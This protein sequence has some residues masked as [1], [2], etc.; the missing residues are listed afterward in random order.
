MPKQAIVT[1]VMLEGTDG[2]KMSTSQGNIISIVDEPF[3]MFGKIMSLRDELIIKYFTMCTD[4]TLDE[5]KEIEKLLKKE[6]PRDIKMRLA[7]EIVTLYHNEKAATL[8]RNSFIETFQKGGVPDDIATYTVKEGEE[9]GTVLVKEGV[10]PSKSE[11]RRLIE[12]NAV[13]REDD[14]V[15]TDPKVLVTDAIFKIGKKRFAKIVIEK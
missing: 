2:N 14:T 11:W 4:T 7:T 1:T 3:D 13:T 15:I 8:A 6:N 9:L 10:V 12:S 5:I